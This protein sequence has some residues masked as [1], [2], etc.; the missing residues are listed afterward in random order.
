MKI[1]PFVGNNLV[2][3]NLLKGKIYATIEDQIVLISNCGTVNRILYFKQI[4]QSLKRLS[5]ILI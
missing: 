4:L 2:L 5:S 3:D 1:L